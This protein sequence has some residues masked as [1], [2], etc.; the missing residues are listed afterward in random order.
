MTRHDL[1]PTE[2]PDFET[3]LCCAVRED[4]MQQKKQQ[5]R[6]VVAGGMQAQ[7]TW[8]SPPSLENTQAT[9][10]LIFR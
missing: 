3:L 6:F 5:L 8:R 9:R 2:E 7:R 4:Q 10:R 1:E